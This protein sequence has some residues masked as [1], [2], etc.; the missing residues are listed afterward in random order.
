MHILLAISK[1]RPNIDIPSVE[2]LRKSLGDFYKFPVHQIN[3]PK[4][5]DMNSFAIFGISLHLADCQSVTMP[6]LLPLSAQP[7]AKEILQKCQKDNL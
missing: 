2:N 6:A 5:A 3:N 1:D 7:S 4:K